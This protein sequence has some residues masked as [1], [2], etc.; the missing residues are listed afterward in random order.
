[1]RVI[2]GL[3]Y[4]FLDAPT[5]KIVVDE[6]VRLWLIKYF[7]K[8]DVSCFQVT[9]SHKIGTFQVQY[10]VLLRIADRGTSNGYEVTIKG[11]DKA[12]D[13]AADALGK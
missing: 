5:R 12:L 11:W 10:N 3:A 13:E 2:H 6:N 4:A 1:L 8:F 7:Q 9:R